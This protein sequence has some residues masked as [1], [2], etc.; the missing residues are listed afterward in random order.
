MAISVIV[1]NHQRPHSSIGY[2]MSAEVHLEKKSVQRKWKTSY[3]NYVSQN[4]EITIKYIE[5]KNIF[6][7]VKGLQIF[8]TS[9]TLNLRK[10][11]MEPLFRIIKNYNPIIELT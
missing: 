5:E 10:Q 2:K 11:K 9:T 7:A 8:F 1:Y 4:V 6:F 3:S